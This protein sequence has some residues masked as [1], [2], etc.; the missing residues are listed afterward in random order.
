MPPPTAF[1]PKGGQLY[2][3][4][5]EKPTEGLKTKEYGKETLPKQKYGK[6]KENT[7]L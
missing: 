3:M 4:Q 5:G 2:H 7:S 6:E 1:L